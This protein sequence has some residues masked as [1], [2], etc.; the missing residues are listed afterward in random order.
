M[1]SSPT[2]ISCSPRL[3][4]PPVHDLAD[5]GHQF[6]GSQGRD[7]KVVGVD[8][9]IVLADGRLIHD[10]QRRQ[11]QLAHA[12]DYR[13]RADADRGQVQQHHVQ[14]VGVRHIFQLH[15]VAARPAG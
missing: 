15:H 6:G 8:G 2:R 11:G 13:L 7:D 4:V 3:S 12:L 9:R 10:Q 1:V 5:T 14:L